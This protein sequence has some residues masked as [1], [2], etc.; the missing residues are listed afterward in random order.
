MRVPCRA[1][2]RKATGIYFPKPPGQ[3]AEPHSPKKFLQRSWQCIDTMSYLHVTTKA[4]DIKIVKT[5]PH[6]TKPNQVPRRIG[7]RVCTIRNCPG[8]GGG[9]LT[10]VGCTIQN[11]LGSAKFV[12]AL[13]ISHEINPITGHGVLYPRLAV[14][15]D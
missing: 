9:D 3:N 15:D 8:S 5:H 2:W 12:L 14:K 13:T 7:K 6:A 11:S 4:L 1:V 10:H